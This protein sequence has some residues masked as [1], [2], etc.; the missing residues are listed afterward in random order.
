MALAVVAGLPLVS[1]GPASADHLPA[2]THDEVAFRAAIGPHTFEDFETGFETGDVVTNQVPGVT[3]GTDPGHSQPYVFASSS[4]V[5]FGGIPDTTSSGERQ[6]FIASFSPPVSAIGFDLTSQDPSSSPATVRYTFEGGSSSEI[7]VENSGGSESLPT[8]VGYQAQGPLVTEVRVTSGIENASQGFEEI[9]LDDISFAAAS[10][11]PLTLGA[12]RIAYASNGDGDRDIWVTDES[13]AGATNLTAGHPGH[14]SD[15][16]LSPDGSRIAFVSDRTSQP[17][18]YAI[19]VMDVDGTDPVQVTDGVAFDADPVWSPDGTKIAFASNRAGRF[20]IYV[21]A[22]RGG[23]ATKVSGGTLGVGSLDGFPT[24]S[25]DGGTIAFRSDRGGDFDIWTT[26][27]G[28]EGGFTEAQLTD[29]PGRDDVPSY[30]PDGSIAFVSD[31]GGERDPDIWVMGPDGRDQRPLVEQPGEQAFPVWS[32]DGRRIAF[33]TF[34]GGAADSDLHVLDVATGTTGATTALVGGPGNQT[35]A[36]WW[37]SLSLTASSASTLPGAATVDPHDIPPSAIPL[38]SVA[39][40]AGT[41]LRSVDIASSPL[42]SVPLRSV[43]LRSVPL[44]SVPLRSVTLSQIPLRSVGASW[45][46]VLAGTPLAGVPLQN[47]TLDQLLALDPAP[48]GLASITLSDVDLASTPLRSVSMVSLAMGATPLRSVPV[49]GASSDPFTNWC[50][51]LA[52]LGYTCAAL[53]LTEDSPILALDLAGVP[54]RSVPLR[55]VPLRSVPLRSV[56]VESLPL[57]SVPLRSVRLSEIELGGLALTAIDDAAK[58]ALF[59]CSTGCAEATLGDAA[60]NG[61]LTPAATLGMLF[62]AVDTGVFP[63]EWDLLDLL[64]GLVDVDDYPWETLPVE[65]IGIHDYAPDGAPVVR[66]DASFAVTGVGA[67]VGGSAT[68]TLPPGFRYVRGSSTD[69]EVALPDPVVAGTSLSWTFPSLAAGATQTFSFDVRPG[70]SLRASAPSTLQVDVGTTTSSALGR[71]PVTV[72]EDHESMSTGAAGA[73]DV[74]AGAVGITA[75]TL[76]LSHI[77]RSGDVD[78]FELPAPP[79]GTRLQVRLGIQGDTDLDVALLDSTASAPLRSVP[80]RSV[81]LRSVPIPDHGLTADAGDVHLSAETLDDIPGTDLAS[82]PLR[83]VSQNRSSADEL[84]DT[85]SNV[86]PADVGSYLIQVSGFNGASSDQ[87]YVLFVK[88]YAPPPPPACAGARTFPYAGEGSAGAAPPTLT[89]V[90]TLILT[91]QERLGD[92]YGSAAAAT[93][94]TK[95]GE[96]AGAAGVGGVVYPIEADPAA[97]GALAAWDADPCSP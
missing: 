65:E 62:D 2:V 7:S 6:V 26:T 79:K 92:T 81:P 25:P 51:V 77:A 87:P 8:Y 19:W 61:R 67:P 15:P 21:V 3:F 93:V 40:V 44:R 57:R 24:W 60:T 90:E 56:D 95:L 53:G 45:E 72:V 58:P 49:P 76:V 36:S 16:H 78:Y 54:L 75:N 23:D 28:P 9:A 4:L 14:D 46:A 80:L 52:S 1:P 35:T 22:A 11:S 34:A 38:A 10:S 41:P 43:P 59:T 39:D 83:S 85:T 31:R 68:V 97:A 20:D 50:T 73:N 5:L 66:Y 96:L 89:G 27:S 70:L 82:T 37:S 30:S 69:G 32:P 13:G 91:S 12:S 18:A 84:I 48:A 42:R 33:D 29:D 71:A 88:Q 74:P 55:S 63:E 64:Q 17:G 86:E 94:M 47:V